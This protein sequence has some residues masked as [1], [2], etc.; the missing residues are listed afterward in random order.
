MFLIARYQ[1]VGFGGVSTFQKHVVIRV[2]RYIESPRRY[3]G[4]AMVLDNL[5][6]L[7]PKTLANV[8]LWPSQYFSI[9]LKD[10]AGNVETNRPSESK[11]KNRALQ[12]GGFDGSGDQYIRIDY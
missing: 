10:W 3:H 12:P 11:Q 8:Q 5:Q 4:V 9:F 7:L 6:D 1:I 2:M